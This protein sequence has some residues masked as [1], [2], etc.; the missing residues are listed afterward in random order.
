VIY[1]RDAQ[2]AASDPHAT[3]EG[4]SCFPQR[5]SSFFLLF[6]PFFINM[7]YAISND[8]QNYKYFMN[9]YIYKKKNIAMHNVL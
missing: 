9:R 4:I 6:L 5:V 1:I 8:L 2:M 7:A 3:R